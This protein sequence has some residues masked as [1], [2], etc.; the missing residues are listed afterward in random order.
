[1]RHAADL[2]EAAAI[3]RV[4]VLEQGALDRPP[5]ADQRPAP[6]DAEQARVFL[7]VGRLVRP[8]SARTDNARDHAI[9][10][11]VVGGKDR[12]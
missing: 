10:I 11:E 9:A 7:L 5:L 2:Q 1:M 4:I 3:P 6:R 12:T 8:M